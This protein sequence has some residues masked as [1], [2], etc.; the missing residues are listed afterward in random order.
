MLPTLESLQLSAY[1]G[2]SRIAAYIGHLKVEL[3][4]ASVPKE[5][6]LTQVISPTCCVPFL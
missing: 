4:G 2:I 6:E 3:G 1:I 5:I